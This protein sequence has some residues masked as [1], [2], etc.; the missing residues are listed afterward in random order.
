MHNIIDRAHE[1]QVEQ[2][3]KVKKGRRATRFTLKW[4]TAYIYINKKVWRREDCSCLFLRCCFQF[5]QRLVDFWLYNCKPAQFNWE[6]SHGTKL[7]QIEKRHQLQSWNVQW[8][9]ELF[10]TL[11]NNSYVIFCL[12]SIDDNR[13]NILTLICAFKKNCVPYSLYFFICTLN[14]TKNCCW[15]NK[16]MYEIITFYFYNVVLDVALE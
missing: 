15:F 3:Q 8:G 12:Q 6:N 1:S 2:W 10:C 9:Q 5:Q 13:T 7:W 4:P 14:L 16:L 11:K